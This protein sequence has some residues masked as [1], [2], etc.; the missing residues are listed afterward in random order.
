MSTPHHPQAPNKAD[1]RRK[2][3]EKYE[4]TPSFEP[5]AVY[6]PDTIN[7]RINHW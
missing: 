3:S 2:I 7:G 6:D 4:G 1:Y 5:D